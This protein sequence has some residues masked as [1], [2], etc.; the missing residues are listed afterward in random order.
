MLVYVPLRFNS[1]GWSS[2][3]V[4]RFSWRYTNDRF[5]SARNVKFGNYQFA[6]FGVSLYRV[7]NM[8]HRDIFPKMGG[9]ISILYSVVPFSGENFGSLLYSSL[10]LYTPGIVKG[11][12]VKFS[13]ALQQQFN[14][15]KN[16]LM[17]NAIAFPS[18]Y[19]DRYSNW[20]YSASAEYAMPLYT[21][22]IS[23]TPLLYIRRI[24]LKPFA[25]FFR[26]GGQSGPENLW[27]AGGDL[28]FD[29][30]LLGISYPLVLGI[31]GGVNGEKHTFAEFL[32]KTPL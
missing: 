4:P 7:R 30:N 31:R 29:L 16:Y 28:L 10:Y 27:A 25:T 12:G 6:S 5:Y 2:G 23:L 11:H 24:Q 19:Q 18:G 17:S 13:A 21:G 32:F 22:D 15:G 3:V 1:G 9:G 20:A 14:E 8:A 26:N